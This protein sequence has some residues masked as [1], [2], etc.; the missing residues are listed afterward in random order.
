MQS[1]LNLRY[2]DFKMKTSKKSTKFSLED[3]K[4]VA[5]LAKL[6]LTPQEEKKL[7]P[8]L[9]E[10]LDYVSQLTLVP[11]EN[12]KVTSQVTGLENIFREDEIDTSR[13][14]TQEE[15]LSNAPATYNG[16][17]KVKAIFE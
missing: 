16:F 17:V 14:L 1:L 5:K 3:V 6:K 10:I 15:A 13:M 7:A 12:V 2:N 8:Q 4:H 9:A 11:T